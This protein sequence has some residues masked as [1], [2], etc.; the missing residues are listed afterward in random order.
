MDQKLCEINRRGA[1]D[2]TIIF[3]R[4]ANLHKAQLTSMY[5]VSDFSENNK[6]LYCYKTSLPCVREMSVLERCLY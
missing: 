5:F 6:Y 1:L 4:H 3:N 2:K